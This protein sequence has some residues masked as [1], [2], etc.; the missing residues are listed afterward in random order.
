MDGRLFQMPSAL[1]KTI[2]CLATLIAV[3]SISPALAQ[4]NQPYGVEVDV[5]L[6][7]AVDV[8]LSMDLREQRLQR[9]GYVRALADP[10]VHRTIER[11]L[12]GRIAL[13]YVEWAGTAQHRTIIDWTLIDGAD[14]ALDISAALAEAPISR[15]RRTSISA[16]ME[17]AAEKIAENDFEGLRKVIDISGDGA[18]N[19]GIL[20]TTARDAVLSQGIVIN[21]LPFVPDPNGPLGLFD[22][23]ELDIYYEDCVIGGPGAFSLPVRDPDDFAEAIRTKLLLEISGEQPARLIPASTTFEPRIPC[24]IGE[25]QWQMFMG[26]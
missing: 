17:V 16:A 5:E 4:T 22:M 18:N 25:R 10:E 19:Q 14:A 8:S 9:D 13:T 2:A 6:V 26:R 12:L 1:F 21:G 7:I 23:P 3:P 20:V 15:V 11:G 24:D